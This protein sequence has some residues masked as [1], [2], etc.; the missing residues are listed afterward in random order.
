MKLISSIIRF[1]YVG[2]VLLFSGLLFK[3]V[4]FFVFSDRSAASRKALGKKISGVAEF[5]GPSYIKLGQFLSTRPDLIGFEM[6]EELSKLQDKLKPFPFKSAKRMVEKNY[7]RDLYGVFE[8]FEENAA[9]AASIAQVHKAK[10]KDGSEVAVKILRPR[11]AKIIAKDIHL[12]FIIARVMQFFSGNA[13]RLRCVE[14]VKKL[15]EMVATELDLRLEAAAA[16]VLRKNLKHEKHIIVP[17]IY[18]QHSFRNVM[19]S[20]WCNGVSI[21]EVA[22]ISALKLDKQKIVRNLAVTFFN[23]A[24]RDG[25]F[26]ADLHPGNILVNEN[27]EIILIDFG[28][29]GTL[30]DRSRIFVAE[31]LYGFISRDYERVARLHFE[32]GYVPKTASQEKFAL[33]CRSIGE[34][35]IG[36]SVDQISIAKLM[37]QLLEISRDFNIEL[38]P[39]LI[40]L[41][42]TLVTLEGV[43]YS[44]YSAVNMWKLA[45]PWIITWGKENLSCAAQLKRS[46]VEYYNIFNKLPSTLKSLERIIEL[47][48]ARMSKKNKL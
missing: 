41:Q 9:A 14:V 19:V 17:K 8:R 3:L 2:F 12:F 25:F 42:K 1:F 18:W 45:E 44:L 43:G 36:L 22:K 34:P 35:I 31:M 7:G 24:F 23:Q 32:I 21:N 6:S 26:H 37:K 47:F 4:A 27:G 38:Q 29:M 5:L 48:E 13:K 20:K 16:D 39:Q 33:A 10:L 15:K 40:L 46:S 28:I 11:V 30:D